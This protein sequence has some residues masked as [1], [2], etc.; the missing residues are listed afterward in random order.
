M[1]NCS[2]ISVIGITTGDDWLQVVQRMSN[3]PPREDK[4]KQRVY[5][6]SNNYPRK[7][8]LPFPIEKRG[9]CSL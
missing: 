3:S 7:D 8:D 5:K 9:L 6:Q 2:Y 1:T 4:L